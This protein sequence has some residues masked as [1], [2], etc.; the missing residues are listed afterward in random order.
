MNNSEGYLGLRPFADARIGGLIGLLVGDA[1]GVAFEFKTPN[2][3]PPRDMIEM[4]PPTGYRRSHAGVPVGTW[5]DDGAQALCLLVSLLERGRFS[6]IDFSDRL[7]RWLDDGYMA[8]DGDVFD[9]GVQTANALNRLR[10]GVSPREA[11]GA[12]E[13][14]NGNGSLMRVLPLALW[15]TGPD[16]ALVHDAHLQSL[17]THAHPR[18]LVACAFYCLVARG[19]L[20]ATAD[21]WT[22]ADQR[23]EE[24]YNVWSD[25]RERGGLLIELDVLRRFP[26]TD[27]PS[28]T[29]YVLDTIW[30]AR[31]ALEEDTFEDVARTAILFGHDT[32][33]TA[34]VAC[35]LAGIKFGVEGIPARWLAQLRGFEIMDPMLGRLTESRREDAGAH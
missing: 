9:C 11:G 20:S 17:P 18:S 34:A 14:D 26:K 8:V 35:G 25:E 31:K 24:V 13:R 30:S 5:S 16:D 3:L 12:S 10:D 15:H 21:P 32:D 33:T 22:W 6:L 19:Y 1:L 28:G 7:V 23:L 4:I 2:L 27:Q 29:G